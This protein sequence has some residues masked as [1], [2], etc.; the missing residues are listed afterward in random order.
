M[1]DLATV[2]A[3][4]AE[5]GEAN[6]H[7]LYDSTI[8]LSEKIKTVA[9]QIYRASDVDFA[10]SVLKKLR[11]FEELGYKE[12][13]VCIAKTQNSISHDPKLMGAP[14]DF[15]FPVR[16]VQLYSGAGF[17][18]A[19]AGDIMTMPGLPKLPAALNIDVDDDGM[20]SGLF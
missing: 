1:K 10:P 16:D 3:E 17:V 5:K 12:L 11:E 13:P 2:V 18:V 8:S 7:Y 4:T 6:F 14:K 19:L 9:R 15:I 20:I